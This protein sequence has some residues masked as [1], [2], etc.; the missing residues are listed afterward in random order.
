M[1]CV[2]MSTATGSAGSI[3]VR[4]K[5]APLS[6]FSPAALTASTRALPVST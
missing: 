6:P 4:S 1:S 3:A 2:S 5:S